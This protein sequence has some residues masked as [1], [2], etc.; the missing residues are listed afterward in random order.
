MVAG[1]MF[2][3]WLGSLRL[4]DVS[5]VDIAWGAA[6]AL[7]ALTT[8][9]V[10][11]STGPRG[12]LITG[13]A[14]L[15][16]LRLTWHIGRRKIGTGE[17]F[18]YAAWREEHGE[19]YPLRSLFTVFFFQ[20]VLIWLVSMPVQVA[21]VSPGPAALGVLDL[22]GLAVWVVGIGFEATADRQLKTFL[23]DPANSGKVMDRGL[24]KYSRHPNY[25]GDSLVWWGIFLVAAAT[26]SGWVT[27]FS[28]ILMTWFLMK[29]SGVP[30]L[31]KALAER[32]EGYR[33]YM[34][35]TSPFVPWPPKSPGGS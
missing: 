28:P 31:E 32:R 3:F 15:W 2:L 12:L 16:G 4:R 5:I 19:A 20:A 11:E 26:A 29:V 33:E 18:R 14:V 1:V 23:A 35:R 6:G 7:I 8:Y 9:L 10:T 24:W 25:F 13:M 21:Q 27:L 17:D 30:L 34:K 22:L